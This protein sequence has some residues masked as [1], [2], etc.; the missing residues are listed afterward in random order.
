MA[1]GTSQGQPFGTI[2]SV[3]GQAKIIGVDGSARAVVTCGKIFNNEMI[4]TNANAS[5]KLRLGNGQIVD[6][7]PG[8]EYQVGIDAAPG[9]GGADEGGGGSAPVL[10]Q[11][12]PGAGPTA[13]FLTEPVGGRVI[14]TITETS[15]QATATSP[16]GTVRIL[17]VGDKVFANETVTSSSGG[18]VK[19]QPNSSAK[20]WA[21][22]VLPVPRYPISSKFIESGRTGLGRLTRHGGIFRRPDRAL[23]HFAHQFR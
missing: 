5:V 3:S 4:L 19:S 7:V 20:S 11:G 2:Q 8:S 17:G 12:A 15:G 1:T 10:A 22:V 23:E 16:D 21:T 6:I 9:A 14:G 13:G 18:P